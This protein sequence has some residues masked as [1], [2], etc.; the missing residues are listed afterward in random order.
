MNSD[1]KH[2]LLS[3]VTA[4]VYPL[5]G[6]LAALGTMYIYIGIRTYDFIQIAFGTVMA[7]ATLV[8]IYMYDHLSRHQQVAKSKNLEYVIGSVVIL[9]II[10]LSYAQYS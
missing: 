7:F 1:H 2:V 9:L 4:L 6:V 10:W 8:F 3:A 5:S